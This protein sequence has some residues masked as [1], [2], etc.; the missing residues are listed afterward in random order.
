MII[1]NANLNALYTGFKTV[2]NEAFAGAP[3]DYETLAMVVPSATRQETYAW[4]GM[5]TGFREWLGDRVIQN[6]E[7]HDYSI[8]NL[9]FE[10]TVGVDR[11]DIEDDS[12]GV[13][14]PL[15]ARLGE[16]AARHPDELVYGLLAGG[17][18]GLGYDGQYFFDIDHP[19]GGASVSNF[20]AGAGPAWYLLDVSRVVKP[21][22]FQRR[23]NYAFI[24]M[25][26]ET[27]EA[28]FMRRQF[29]YGVDAR[30]NA[31]YGLWQ[32]AHA[33]KAALDVAGYAAARTAMLSLKADNGKPLGISPRLLVVP[34][35]LEGAALDMVKAERLANGA[36]NTYRN[37]AEVLVSPYLS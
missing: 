22:I 5:S 17:F 27:D 35:A 4:L 28:V 34:P 16:D 13:Y 30:V 15:M 10:D 26:L 25:N 20:D 2:F 29:R 3:S 24:N 7:A 19:V 8:K 21:F 36:T 18:T 12:Y 37:T 23:K 31:G 9:A 6:L 32:F 11:N 1:N 14:R 33:S